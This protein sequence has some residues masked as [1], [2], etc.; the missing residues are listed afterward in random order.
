M[1]LDKKKFLQY[2]HAMPICCQSKPRQRNASTNILETIWN[3]LTL[4]GVRSDRRQAMTVMERIQM[5][6]SRP[7][8]E[9][10]EML[11]KANTERV[12]KFRAN[13]GFEAIS[14]NTALGSLSPKEVEYILKED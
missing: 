12:A 5:N 9:D 13:G 3:S 6:R 2:I 8:G 4:K 14:K 7:R 1:M 11:K 10:L